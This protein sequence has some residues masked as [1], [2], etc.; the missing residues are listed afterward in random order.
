MS[1]RVVHF[2]IRLN[3]NL[4]RCSPSHNYTR[5]VVC[6]LEVSDILANSLY[7]LPTVAALLN[8]VAIKTF[9]KILIKSG[10]IR[11]NL[12]KFVFYRKNIFLFEHLIWFLPLLPDTA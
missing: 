1:E 7:H 3:I 12:L 9:C 11:N 6:S 2:H 8:V 10:L 4:C 5:A